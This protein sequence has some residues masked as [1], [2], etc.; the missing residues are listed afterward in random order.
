MVDSRSKGAQFERDIVK[1]L[2]G[3]FDDNDLNFQCKRNLDQYQAKNLS[4][5][6]IPYHAV[7]CKAYK[8]GWWWRPEWWAQV[9]ESAGDNIPV[10]VY[11]FN[12][13]SPRVCLPLYA[14]NPEWA[15]DNDQTAV[16]TMDQWFTV[17]Q[18][19]WAHYANKQ[20]T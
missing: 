16:I 7:E 12:N 18:E 13:K 5:I 14:I 19:N 11:K 15:R 10:L 17:M 1:K 8:D 2:N 6:E 9:K 3:F 4:D 20:N